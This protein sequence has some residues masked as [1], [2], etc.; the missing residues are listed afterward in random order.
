MRK[1]TTLLDQL[2]GDQE[3]RP[4]KVLPS[5]SGT[6]CAAIIALLA[7][8]V[9]GAI[10]GIPAVALAAMAMAAMVIMTFVVPAPWRLHT[11]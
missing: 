7:S 8:A 2:T 9:I 3:R 1:S 4:V 10:A 11:E 5:S 6:L